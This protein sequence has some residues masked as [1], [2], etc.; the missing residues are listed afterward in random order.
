MLFRSQEELLTRLKRAPQ[1]SPIDFMKALH[2][3]SA[4]QIPEL[5]KYLRPRVTFFSVGVDN[6]YGHPT[7]RALDLYG[8]AGRIFRTD[9]MGCLALAKRG[10]NLIVVTEPASPW[11][12]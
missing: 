11:A 7:A 6:P 4:V 12:I 8:A 3:G 10:G 9:V 5:I 2:H 1:R